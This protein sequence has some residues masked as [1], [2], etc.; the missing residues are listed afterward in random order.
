MTIEVTNDYGMMGWID[1]V[2]IKM[3][4]LSCVVGDVYVIYLNP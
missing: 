4:L 2:C 1:K 3:G